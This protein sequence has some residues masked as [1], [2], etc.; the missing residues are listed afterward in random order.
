MSLI[1][2]SRGGRNFPDIFIPQLCP[3]ITIPEKRYFS[4]AEGRE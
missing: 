1:S 4:A 2:S 3:Q